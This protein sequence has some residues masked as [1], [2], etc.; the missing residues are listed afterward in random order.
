MLE[1]KDQSKTQVLSWWPENPPIYDIT[2]S[3]IENAEEGPFF[4]KE[5]PDR[6]LPPESEWLEFLGHK[7]VAP[8]GVPAGPLLNSK[9]IGLASRLGFDVLCYKTIRSAENSGHSLPNMIYI[10]CDN[11]LVPGKLPRELVTRSCLPKEMDQ[12]AVT[13]SFGMPSRSAEYLSKDI[14]QANSM[15]APGQVMIVSVVGSFCDGTHQAFVQDFVT[16]AIQAK[17]YGAKVIEVNYSCPNVSSGEGEIYT[18]PETV[19]DITR[20]VVKA[21]NDTPL[22]IKVGTFTDPYLMEKVLIAAAKAG[23]RGVCG[24]NTISMKVV[25]KNGRPAL[26][27]NRLKSGI[28]GYPIREAAINFTRNAHEI[29]QKNQLGLTILGTGGAVLSEHFTDFL[30]AGADIAMAATGMLW[31]PYLAY[32]YH[33][34]DQYE[35]S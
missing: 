27:E 5:I 31:N 4:E 28:C 7:I 1:T 32:N 25:D 10:D 24:I 11:Q 17:E 21:I 12:I 9:W 35:Y 29:N 16:V 8:L 30:D 13:N 26:G 20:R 34:K 33:Q 14:S 15:L 22:I 6:I 3:Y 23:A 19:Y 18:C 2:K